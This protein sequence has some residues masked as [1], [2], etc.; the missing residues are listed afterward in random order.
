MKRETIV[1]YLRQSVLFKDASLAEIES[2]VGVARNLR[3]EEGEYVY[4]KGDSSDCVYFVVQGM[5]ELVWEGEACSAQ[6]VGRITP[7]G[8]FG[9]TGVL[10]KKERSLHAR[11]LSDL[12]VICFDRRFFCNVIL[13]NPRIHKRLDIA[14]AERLRLAFIDQIDSHSSVN[15]KGDAAAADDF[16]LFKKRESLLPI[17]RFSQKRRPDSRESQTTKRIQAD[18]EK[19]AAM[20]APFMVSG[21]GGTGKSVILKEIH[22]RSSRAGGQYLELDL[23]DYDP[24]TLPQKLLGLDQDNSPFSQARR[25]GLFEQTF[26]G[27]IVFLHAHLMEKELQSQLVEILQSSSY[28]HVG[29]SQRVALES[30]VVLVSTYPLEQ[31]RST[32]QM[33]PELADI[34]QNQQLLLPPLREHKVDIPRLVTYYLQRFSREYGKNITKVTPETLGLFMNY[35]WPGN[36]SELS[37]VIRRA[38]MLAKNDE[39]D[40]EQ[41]LLGLPKSEGKWEFN[42]LRLSW[43]RRFLRSPFFPKVPRFM[44][45]CVL[46]L[47]V[48]FLFL[49]PSEPVSNIGLTIGWYIG[50]PLLFF[51]F[52]FLARTWCSV[53]SLAVP[54]T[55]LQSVL[56]PERRPPRFIQ[57]KSGWIM[58]VLCILVF[59]IEIVWNAYD[60]PYLTGVIILAIASGSMFFSAFFSR[61]I[62]CRYL[63]PLGAVN[64]IFAMPSVVELRSN[65]HVCLNRCQ[66]HYCFRGEAAHPGCPMFRHPYL[67]DNNRDCIMCGKCVKSCKNS[68]IQV[69]VRIAPQ[70]LWALETPRRA[71]SFLIVSLAAIFFPF[72]LQGQFRELALQ[73]AHSIVE[74]SGLLLPYWLVATVLFCGLIG[75]FQV[76][77]YVL[78]TVQSRYAGI[79]RNFLLPMLGYS[80]I[81]LV[82]GGFM[83][84]HLEAFVGGAGRIVPNIQQLLGFSYSY[85]NVRLISTDSAV[86]LQIIT[87]FGGL[88]AALYATYRLTK[89]ALADIPF[90]SKTLVFPFSFLCLLAVLYL[91]MV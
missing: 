42:L 89:R 16:L 23:R 28:C 48:F 91:F 36:L 29:G 79:D 49:G 63:C 62:W 37:S 57:E 2:F 70:E 68:S 17:S 5:I 69:N 43:F 31:L 34:V 12:V 39:I 51:S 85:E 90:S 77:Y 66:E 78:V 64:A 15:K 41:V 11:A 4:K 86:V 61:R 8:H 22:L 9:E 50:W 58:A 47:T 80:F 14:L 46:L 60:N 33:I 83:A 19:F 25:A 59:W 82:L 52:F 3:F 74:S 32:G 30:R 53:C 81:P 20:K 40:P 55:L 35:D 27:T 84:L 87:V 21:E 44:V 54:G 76:G 73:M 72:A 65:S 24:I 88:M 71:D 6:I 1:E 7:G 38:V 45:G 67:V 75:L 26:G 18:V 56:K 10:T 13:A